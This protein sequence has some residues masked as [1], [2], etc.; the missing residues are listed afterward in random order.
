[1]QVGVARNRTVLTHLDSPKR[2]ITPLSVSHACPLEG[3]HL[4][5]HPSLVSE[6]LLLAHIGGEYIFSGGRRTNTL[7]D[8]HHDGMHGCIR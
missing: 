5:E 3:F 6:R 1:M 8:A 2:F 4:A 7:G